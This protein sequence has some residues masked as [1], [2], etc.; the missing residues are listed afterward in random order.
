MNSGNGW[1]TETAYSGTSGSYDWGA[2]AGY[3]TVNTVGTPSFNGSFSQAS[4][5]VMVLVTLGAGTPAVP[6]APNAPLTGNVTVRDGDLNV[7]GAWPLAGQSRR[8]GCR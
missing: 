2:V 3:Q 6:A 4:F 1:T 8:P 7:H 5:S